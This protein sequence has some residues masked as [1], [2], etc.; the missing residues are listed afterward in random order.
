MENIKYRV[1]ALLYIP[2]LNTKA[3]DKIMNHKFD[4]MTSCCFCLEDTIQDDSLELAEDTLKETLIKLKE[5]SEKERPLIFVRVRTPEHLKRIH[6]K[7]RCVHDVITGYSLPKFDASN[8][9]E[10]VS[11]MMDINYNSLAVSDKKFYFM[12]ILESRMIADISTRANTLHHIK[13]I[14]EPVS[15]YIL[16]IRVGGNDFCNLYGLR[17]NVKQ[18]IYDIGVVRDILT[19][20]VNVFSF[21]YT[22]SGPVW[23]YFKRNDDDNAW[24]NGLNRELELDRCYGFVGKTCIH[25]SQLPVV[26]DSLKVCKEDY[27]D[28]CRILDW[29]PKNMAVE[30]GSSSRM[31]EVKCHIKWAHKTKALGDIYGI[32][33]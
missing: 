25:P 29:K 11:I 22:I 8:A 24:L 2:S 3:A 6:K 15:D 7:F 9:A 16:N 32:K 1:G 21:D 30:K 28:A 18:T 10:Y 31:N 17:R 26:Y 14:I 19:D 23:E 5:M 4:K 27:E 13:N 20:I 12:P 33:E